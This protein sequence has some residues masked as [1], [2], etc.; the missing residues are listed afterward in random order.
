MKTK[1]LLRT[2]SILVVLTISLSLVACGSNT[3]A[4]AGSSTAAKTNETKALATTEADTQP[5]TLKVFFSNPDKTQGLGLLEDMGIQEWT[6]ANPNIKIELE[7]LQDDPYQKKFQTYLASGDVP[8][9]YKSWNNTSFMTPVINGGYAAELNPSDYDSYGFGP[10]A[11][12]AYTFDGKLYGIPMFADTWVL[13]YNDGLF[14]ANGVKVPETYDDLLAAAKAFRAKGIQ[15]CAQNGKEGWPVYFTYQ[16]LALKESGNQKLIYDACEKKTSFAKE[17][18]MLAAAKDLKALVDARF[19]M[20]G[21]TSADYGAARAMFVQGKAAMYIMGSW[22]MGMA[23][24]AGV[25]D[26]IKKNIRATKIPVIQGKGDADDLIYRI[27]GGYSVNAKSEN[28]D[29]AKK[30]ANFMTG[31]DIWAKNAWQKSICQTPSDSSKYVTGN[32]SQVQNDLAKILKEAKTTSG[33]LFGDK[34]T[35]AFGTDVQKLFTAYISGI[36]TPEQLLSELDK[37]VD[38]DIK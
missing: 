33:L 28:L 26:D 7:A 27:G 21:Y 18:A 15:P 14:K 2:L 17:A 9:V 5:V 16:A 3:G 38:K 36:Y 29:V 31:P 10:G 25:S 24:D 32:E 13:Y 11:L 35:P 8:D 20:D 1:M 19:F 6:K 37:L 34:Y 4:P 12:D 22:E 30:F 23:T